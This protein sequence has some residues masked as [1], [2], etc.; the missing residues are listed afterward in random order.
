MQQR[1]VIPKNWKGVEGG[2]ENAVMLLKQKKLHEAILVLQEILE[3]S[4]TEAKVWH[5]LGRIQQVQRLHDEAI[6][7]FQEARRYYKQKQSKQ[8]SAPISLRLAK[9]LMLQGD[10]VAAHTM[11]EELLFLEPDN[12]ELQDIKIEWQGI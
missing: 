11:L 5:L 10:A 7:S 9:L 8:R 6:H 12:I 2:F 4:H 3:F 1:P